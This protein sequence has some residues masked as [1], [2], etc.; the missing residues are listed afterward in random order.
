M[1][2]ASLTR[3]EWD[4]MSDETAARECLALARRLLHGLQFLGLSMN[5]YAGQRHRL[6]RFAIGRATFVLIPGGRVGLGFE[7]HDFRPTDRQATSFARSARGLGYEGA[8]HDFVDERTSK[9]RIA[10][11]PA[12][13]IE[14]E[15]PDLNQ[16]GAQ[17]A[18]LE[19]EASHEDVI[20]E[21]AASGFRPPTC[22]EWEYACGAGG[23]S[24][25]RW[26]NDCPE[27]FTPCSAKAG[28]W[29]RP[30]LFG[31]RIAE[32]PYEMDL[33]SDGPMALG[34]DGGCSCCGGYGNFF[35]WLPLA[36]AHRDPYQNE[37]LDLD[38]PLSGESLRIRRVI[39]I[40]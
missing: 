38:D 24:L 22:D 7:V 1:T 6:A 32:N 3:S 34:G 28:A 21:L 19:G 17:A 39:D 4:R 15:S 10:V 13:L 2:L 40:A 37:W 30:N 18:W 31:L 26:G 23:P 33:V 8:I 16:D 11:L 9:P 36:T 5:A 27:D 29:L 20:A 35:E 12:L 25:F 14:V